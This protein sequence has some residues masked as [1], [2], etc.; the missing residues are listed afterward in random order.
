MRARL[1]AATALLVGL[2]LLT[3]GIQAG[4]ATTP[5]DCES[6]GD[7]NHCSSADKYARSRIDFS[8]TNDEETTW[9][10]N[11][12]SYGGSLGGNNG[13]GE[14]WRMKRMTDWRHNGTNWV[15]VGSTGG[16][17]WHSNQW[18]W[19]STYSA[20]SPRTVTNSHAVA[21]VGT[22]EFKFCVWTYPD[23]VNAVCSSHNTD[24]NYTDSQGDN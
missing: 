5:W 11:T 12:R 14:K 2:L 19:S 4:A 18:P 15:Q 7:P 16:G 8:I 13:P 22:F 10:I 9:V 21:V 1:L 3:A 24:Y 23:G 6:A 17:S 20:G